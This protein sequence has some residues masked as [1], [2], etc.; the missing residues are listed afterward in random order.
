MRG[1]IKFYIVELYTKNTFVIP[2]PRATRLS[3]D[4]SNVD[5]GIIVNSN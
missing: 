3:T 4:T 5:V 2:S 1:E